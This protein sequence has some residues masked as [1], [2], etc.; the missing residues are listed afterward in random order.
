MGLGGKRDR[1]D[2]RYIGGLMKRRLR[3]RRSGEEAVE[4]DRGGWPGTERW[5][6][7]RGNINEEK[8]PV[9]LESPSRIAPAENLPR[10]AWKGEMVGGAKGR[11]GEGAK[12]DSKEVR[13]VARDPRRV[14]RSRRASR[15]FSRASRQSVGRAASMARG[16]LA[17]AAARTRERQETWSVDWPSRGGSSWLDDL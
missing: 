9:S 1:K 2:A 13:G 16:G 15:A 5:S 11:R 8:T 6:T 17:Q 3:R 4:V 14:A 10:R 7:W 12:A